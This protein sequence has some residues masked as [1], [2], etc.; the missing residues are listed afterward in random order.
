MLQEKRLEKILRQ[1][2]RLHLPLARL[3]RQLEFFK[4]EALG[5]AVAAHRVQKATE[6]LEYD[7]E[8]FIRNMLFGYSRISPGRAELAARFFPDEK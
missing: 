6:D 4:H 8:R 2:Q 1:M 7:M 3:R 5:D